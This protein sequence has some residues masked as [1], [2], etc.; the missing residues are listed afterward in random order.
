MTIALCEA[1]WSKR[2]SSL[3]SLEGSSHGVR[4]NVRLLPA[5]VHLRGFFDLLWMH[6]HDSGTAPEILLIEGQQTMYSMDAHCSDQACV[7]YLNATHVMSHYQL[8]PFL[9]NL[10][11]VGQQDQIAFEYS[12]A[13]VGFANRQSEAV[14]ILGA[15]ADIPK[16]SEV[17]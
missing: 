2:G 14:S 17:L 9:M 8:P 3:Q 4:A 1:S 10:F 11:V 5:S 13:T 12:S 15:G 6:N 16:F 7:V